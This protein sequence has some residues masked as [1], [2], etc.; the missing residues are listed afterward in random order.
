MEKYGWVRQA[1][2]GDITGRMLIACWISEAA[3]TRS[4]Y[5]EFYAPTN[6]LLYT[7]KRS[8]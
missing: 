8:H 4:E 2:N 5:A 3:E 7:I 6:A 1:T